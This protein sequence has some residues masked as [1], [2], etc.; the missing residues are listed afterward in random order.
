MLVSPWTWAG[1]VYYAGV[2]WGWSAGWGVAVEGGVAVGEDAVPWPAA[3][4]ILRPTHERPPRHVSL[5]PPPHH[6]ATRRQHPARP[7][8]HHQPQRT[9]PPRGNS[10]VPRPGGPRPRPARLLAAGTGVCRTGRTPAAPTRQRITEIEHTIADLQRRLRNQLLGLEDDHLEPE[11]RRRITSRIAELEQAIADH[12]ASL[13]KLHADPDIPMLTT[14]A[15]AETLD[16]VPVFGQRLHRLPQP[17]L[18]RLFD[19]LDLTITYD[20][21]RRVGRMRIALASDAQR[22]RGSG[23]CPGRDSNARPTA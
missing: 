20:P 3:V 10:R 17:E 14:D 1:G 15:L 11:T 4:R 7:P 22:V 12:Q 9:V 5:L 13:G 2:R 6:H 23:P 19:S 18:R 16:Q 8:R 21:G